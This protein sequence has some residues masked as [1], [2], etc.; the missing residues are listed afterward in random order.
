MLVA[1]EILDLQHCLSDILVVH[2]EFY[3][4]TVV[5][6]IDVQSE[7]Q[8]GYSNQTDS[9]DVMVKK[10]TI[11]SNNQQQQ[12]VGF[13]DENPG[14]KV[15]IPLNRSFVT[16][17]SS[18]NVELG[19]FLMRPVRIADVI[20]AEGSSLTVSITPFFEYF[21]DTYIKR[22]L[23]NYGFI[24]CDLHIK[25]VINASPFYYGAALVSWEPLPDYNC[26]NSA[27]P[28]DVLVQRSQFPHVW[29]YPQTSQG[30]EMVLP[31]FYPSN[32]LDTGGTIPFQEMGVLRIDSTTLRNA[33]SVVGADVNI[34]VYAW[35]ENV[36]LSAPTMQLVLQSAPQKYSKDEYEEKG[37]ISKP[38][39]AIA[40]YA[41]YLSDVPVL[42]PFATATATIAGGV[43]NL[44]SLFGYSKVPNVSP[45]PAM[46]PTP[47]P[48]FAV[49][50]N[51][52]PIEKLT[53]DSKNELSIDN[54]VCGAPAADE[55]MVS[56]IVT[57]ESY[58][59][60]A[61]W[62]SVDTTDTPLFATRVNPDFSIVQSGTGCTY[63]A[64]T[65][66]A[67]ISYL[68]DRWRGDIIFRF[69]IVC[70]QYH[71]GRLAITW[72]PKINS[73]YSAAGYSPQI[74]TKVIDISKDT[75]VEFVVPYT[76]D[77]AYK[78]T[79]RPIV[80]S[81]IFSTTSN[82]SVFDDTDNGALYLKVLNAQT[83]PILSA[84]IDILV[85][86]RGSDNLEYSM[87][88]DLEE[89]LS[90]YDV[91]SQPMSYTYDELQD[92]HQMGVKPSTA[93]PYI[94]LVYNGEC[95]KS[96]RAIAQR[97]TPYK[98]TAYDLQ[99]GGAP[100]ASTFATFKSR[101]SRL[102]MYPGYDPNG[103]DAA[104]GI[105]SG[106]SQSYNWVNW[107]PYTF[108]SLMYIGNRGSIDYSLSPLKTNGA[109]MITYIS[110]F[111]RDDTVTRNV[112][113]VGKSNGASTRAM[114]ISTDFTQGMSLGH[115]SVNSV[116]TA[117][118]PMYSRYKFMINDPLR[119]TL[120]IAI[121]D[122]DHDM[123]VSGG[124]ILPTGTTDTCGVLLSVKPGVDFSLVFFLCAPILVL[125]DSVPGAA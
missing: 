19:D 86:V 67:H 109:D 113:F 1:G 94:N 65:P 7:A 3:A 93:D 44:A 18:Q 59:T 20:W 124:M 8:S 49:T 58:V 23:E 14:I 83:S 112:N 87:P 81:E 75:D 101:F 28:H 91:Q 88:R 103:L 122:S 97:F 42:G 37:P 96:V 73:P 121:D 38:A 54:R 100:T 35:A 43:G 60:S 30:G 78:T 123:V 10:T 52:E 29:I 117:S 80:N 48:S 108:L 104:L 4:Y 76:Q 105:N 12:T 17:D 66:L 77:T 98:Y 119:R 72:D 89:K 39:S 107:S 27:L 21:N 34:Q 6:D 55:M 69:K 125:Y 41:G 57:R 36:E 11:L 102:P 5:S 16:S 51:Q 61:V 120:G 56:H 33:N 62:T 110:R 40:R 90:P 47:F 26:Y 46:K 85:F 64:M 82:V 53:L 45:V 24:R 68:F 71:K 99:A 84:D 79:R 15:D 116:V 32:Y 2:N 22:K 50:D 31:F 92:H 115:S 13:S 63:K 9:E 106:V 25:L 74:Y 118:A 114:V 111:N 70:S 95:V